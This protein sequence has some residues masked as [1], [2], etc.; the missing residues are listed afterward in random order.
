MNK[1][2]QPVLLTEDGQNF[3]IPVNGSLGLLALGYKGIMLWREKRK[4][5][6]LDNT[7]NPAAQ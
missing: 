2:E 3:E 6:A 4:Q 5:A 7:Q 1:N